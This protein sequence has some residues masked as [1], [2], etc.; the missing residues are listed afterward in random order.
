MKSKQILFS[1]FNLLELDL[2]KKRSETETGADVRPKSNRF[3]K[4]LYIAFGSISPTH[5]ARSCT[6]SYK[7]H[8]L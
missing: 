4:L 2:F 5:T 7:V 1:F 6:R 3:S 8:V